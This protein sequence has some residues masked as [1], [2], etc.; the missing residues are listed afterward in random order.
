[1][2]DHVLGHDS[3][4]PRG[5]LFSLCAAC[6]VGGWRRTKNFYALKCLFSKRE[7]ARQSSYLAGPCSGLCQQFMQL[8]RECRWMSDWPPLVM[9]MRF[10]DSGSVCSHVPFFLVDV[11]APLVNQ[12]GSP[13]SFVH[14]SALLF[15]GPS[16]SRGD[17]LEEK[18]KA[19]K[20]G[21][22]YDSFCDYD[23]LHVLFR[24][25]SNRSTSPPVTTLT[26]VSGGG[27]CE[28]LGSNNN[29]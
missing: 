2:N 29:T 19:D 17:V 11:C 7:T 21:K 26:A 1:M 10:S 8:G 18:V 28:A 25:R 24:S 27:E 22:V 4:V 16:H 14:S 15:P 20:T 5:A 12:S 13:R 6:R 3:R 23:E 9:K